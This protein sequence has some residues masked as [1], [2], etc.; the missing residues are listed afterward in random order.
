MVSIGHYKENNKIK[1][2]NNLFDNSFKYFEY[3]I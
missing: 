1:I 3:R 2:L